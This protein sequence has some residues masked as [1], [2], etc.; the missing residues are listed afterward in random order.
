MISTKLG[1]F[2]D[3][4][5]EDSERTQ[6]RTGK[7]AFLLSVGFSATVG[8]IKSGPEMYTVGDVDQKHA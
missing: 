4:I 2:P 3:E 6:H 5:K 8:F 1:T 7:T